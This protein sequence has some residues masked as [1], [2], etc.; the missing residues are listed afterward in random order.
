V[1][2]SL[3]LKLHIKFCF[4]KWTFFYQTDTVPKMTFTIIFLF[5]L[6]A[7][8]SIQLW[9]N[10]RQIR[11]VQRHRDT[12]PTFF[13]EKITLSS[14]Q[15]AADYTVTKARFNRWI[16]I[17]DGLLLLLWT[18]GGGLQVV[19]NFALQMNWGTLATGV[20][21]IILF[22]FISTILHL[23]ASL[24]ST[25][26]I[27]TKFGFNNT[28]IKT[29]V[30]DFIKS[31]GLGLIIEI[32]LIFLIL[33]LMQSAGQWWW[34][35]A[36]GL[37]FGFALLMSWA[38]PRLIAPLFNKFS[39]LDKQDLKASIQNL[40]DRS[41]FVSKGIFIMDGSRRSSHGNAYFT[42][43]GKSKRIVFFDT[44]LKSLEPQQII[45]ILAHELGHFKH[46]H[47]IKGMLLSA[48]LSLIGFA[49]LAWL[50]PQDDM[51][52]SLGVTTPN[53]ALA[54]L[55]FALVSP[56][57]TFLLNPLMAWHSRKNEF[58]ADRYA[59]QQSDPQD[60]ISALVK[61]YQENANTLTP[62]D[63]HSYFYDS[64]PPALER[65]SYLQNLQAT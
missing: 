18:L 57:F 59:A 8:F 62:D 21:T 53:L 52:R 24:Y 39:P 9:L 14:H 23:P 1:H 32:P 29:F 5:A 30:A 48:V 36:W 22:A 61:L 38:Y 20:L 26:V 44:L 60:L 45:A 56:V 11:H 50:L 27:E 6:G 7:S 31:M 37:W 2:T 58:E 41:G 55:L 17:F 43:L 65:I 28:N 4:A 12:V 49:T 15:K 40:L 63:L 35:Y 51:Y 3:F 10:Q 13:T 16:I 54:L 34:I 33:W 42:G 19:Y 46:K 47:L 25:F 64:H